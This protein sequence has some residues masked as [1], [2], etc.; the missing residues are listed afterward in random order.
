MPLEQQNADRE[1][2]TD[3]SGEDRPISGD[4]KSTDIRVSPIAR[5]ARAGSQAPMFRLRDQHGTMI[6]SQTLLHSRP[7]MLSFFW[8]SASAVCA[9]ELD[10][11]ANA[12]PDIDNAGANLAAVSPFGAEGLK[13]SFPFPILKDEG[14]KVARRFGLVFSV[15]PYQRADFE[16]A[17]YP[18]P[19]LGPSGEAHLS[20]PATYLIDK[21]G[22]ILLSYLDTNFTSRQAPSE[23]VA[24]LV[25][26][27]AHLTSKSSTS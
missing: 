2:H 6:A 4:A 17:G 10:A 23:I 27:K 1:I 8:K 26:I 3:V 15:A 24:A 14:L 5:G 19:I 21:T 20:V 9:A 22:R 11:L 13:T 18:P 25:R 7:L 12:Y 16:N